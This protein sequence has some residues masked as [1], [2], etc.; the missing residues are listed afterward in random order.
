MNTR[1]KTIIEY[2]VYTSIIVFG[3]FFDQLT[4]WLAVK[5]L[6]PISTFPIID[7]VFHFTFLRNRGAAFGMLSDHR[8]VFMTVSTVAIL[9]L[10]VFLY[11]RKAPNLW[12]AISISAIV[13]GGIGNMI[14]RISLGYVVD[15]IDVR[16]IDFAIFNVADCFVTVGAIGLITLLVIDMIADIKKARDKK[17]GK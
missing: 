17:A 10:A 8:W 11:M 16:L 12:Y 3:I 14:D 4:K 6:D 13:S 5:F 9:A 7:D 2:T 1:K 15:F